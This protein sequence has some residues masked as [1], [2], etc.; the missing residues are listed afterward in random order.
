MHDSAI[1]LRHHTL[2]EAR[3]LMYNVLHQYEIG[4]MSGQHCVLIIFILARPVFCFA[5][6]AVN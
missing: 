4:V 3:S 2:M 1:S 6:H 5:A